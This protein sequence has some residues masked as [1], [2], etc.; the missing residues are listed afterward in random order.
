M[1]EFRIIELE[2]TVPYHEGLAKQMT[3]WQ[4]VKEGRKSA[5]I[6]LQHMPTITLGRR[7]DPSHLLYSKE[8]YA[9]RGIDVVKIDRGGSV[10][11]HGPGQLV[12]YIISRVARHGGTHKLVSSVLEL[13]CETIRSF[14]IDS[15]VNNE[16]PG[17]WTRHPLKK[18]AAVGMQIKE[19]ISLH[20][21][22][23]NVDMDLAPFSLI[24]PCGLPEPVT[25]MSM[26]KGEKVEVDDVK[27]K[28]KSLLPMFL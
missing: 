5:L 18:V 8:E 12:G 20:G 25:T 28:I 23:I 6:L 2:G 9:E 3:L 22:A 17:V 21:F 26:E 19:G 14:G 4:Q 27:E 16:M 10:T 13:V 11:Y 15:V 1:V 24:I 7:T